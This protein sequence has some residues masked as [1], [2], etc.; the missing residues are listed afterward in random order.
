MPARDAPEVGQRPLPVAG[1]DAYLGDPLL[2]EPR[3]LVAKPQLVEQ[4]QRGRVDRVTAEVPQEVTV[5]L[6]HRHPQPRPSQQQPEHRP[7][8]PTPRDHT[9]DPLHRPSF[10]QPDP[11]G[12]PGSVGAGNRPGALVAQ[13]I[14]HLTTDQEVAGSS[15]AERASG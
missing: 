2:V 15:P 4:R 5:L 3:E 8:R 6:D 9:V 7:C 14:E 10:T 1:G 11:S 12:Y 13:R